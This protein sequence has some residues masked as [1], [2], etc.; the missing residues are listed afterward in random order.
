MNARPSLTNNNPSLPLPA[1]PP[2]IPLRRCYSQFISPRH[3]TS[4]ASLSTLRPRIP[5][6]SLFHLVLQFQH[7]FTILTSVSALTVPSALARRTKPI[8]IPARFTPTWS[9]SPS[10]PIHPA[11]TACHLRSSYAPAS[12]ARRLKSSPRLLISR[13]K[14]ILL[15][16]A[17]LSS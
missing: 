13:L 1:I 11:L 6:P 14:A 2:S 12:S 10:S 9:R 17:L 8:L 5:P 15:L 3:P 4:I 7:L 16:C